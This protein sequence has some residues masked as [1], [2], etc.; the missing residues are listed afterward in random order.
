MKHRIRLDQEGDRLLYLYGIHM[1]V[2]LPRINLIGQASL[3]EELQGVNRGFNRCGGRG[4]ILLPT[5]TQ[6][7]QLRC[8][9]AAYVNQQVLGD[10]DPIKQSTILQRIA[11]LCCV[12]YDMPRHMS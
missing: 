3:G 2:L 12:R 6:V 8:S 9:R 5:R 10:D 11:L 7:L 4:P 1:L